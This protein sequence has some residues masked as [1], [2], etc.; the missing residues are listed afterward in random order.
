MA[1]SALIVSVIIEPYVRCTLPLLR[2]FPFRPI[3][4]VQLLLDTLPSPH[5]CRTD[6]LLH[7]VA[8]SVPLLLLDHIAV[9]YGA[10]VPD[11]DHRGDVLA[12]PAANLRRTFSAVVYVRRFFFWPGAGVLIVLVRDKVLK[13]VLSPARSSSTRVPPYILYEV[14]V[15]CLY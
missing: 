7:P 5:V 2:L 14:V 12:P 3:L 13:F 6:L 9:H 11:A 10:L 15:L 4:P 1:I 8:C